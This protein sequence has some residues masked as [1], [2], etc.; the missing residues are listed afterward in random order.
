MYS[1]ALIWTQ[2]IRVFSGCS[3]ETIMK[4]IMSGRTKERS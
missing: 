4:I 1:L 3:L 2:Q